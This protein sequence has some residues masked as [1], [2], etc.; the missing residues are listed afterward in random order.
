MKKDKNMK[1]NREELIKALTAI[2]PGLSST[3]DRMGLQTFAFVNGHVVSYGDELSIAYPV[4]GLEDI[5]GSINIDKFYELLRKL[6][7]DEVIIT[8]NTQKNEIN[9]RSGKVRAGL[10]LLDEVAF[11]VLIDTIQPED[12][13]QL[14]EDFLK[15][16]TFAIP[17]ASKKDDL[18]PVMMSLNI[19]DTG[20]I[21]AT[22]GY[23]LARY[24]LSSQMPV[25]TMLLPV[26]S[27]KEL[28]K[29]PV[30]HIILQ[31]GW[32]HFTDGDIIFSSRVYEGSF[33]AFK[34]VIPTEGTEIHFPESM[35]D[36]IARARIFV[37]DRIARNETVSITVDKGVVKVRGE[38]LDEALWFEEQAEIDYDGE[39]IQISVAPE[40]LRDIFQKT[41]TTSHYKYSLTFRGENWVFVSML[42]MRYN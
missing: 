34:G 36:M 27:A 37:R 20:Y 19:T 33:P 9:V 40:V 25:E 12:W 3:F 28:V 42:K 24:E 7:T 30:T 10:K 15:G 31:Q 39:P 5:T 4:A 18:R 14:P 38:N 13:K 23:C 29:Y 17:A 8:H 11:P 1:V 16:L 32:S 35:F 6:T 2:K 22:D 26:S 41:T 21:E